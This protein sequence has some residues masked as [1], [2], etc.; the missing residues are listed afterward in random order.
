M[1]HSGE[2]RQR[3][4][5][6]VREALRRELDVVPPSPPEQ[7]W[8]GIRAAILSK[9]ERSFFSPGGVFSW[10]R[11]T[12]AAAVLLLLAGGGLALSRSPLL[13]PLGRSGC[14]SAQPEAGDNGAMEMCAEEK[15]GLPPLAP[16]SGFALEQAGESGLLTE[17]EH[18]PAALYRRGDETLLWACDSSSSKDLQD[19][20]AELG[21]QLGF[22]IKMASGER[23]YNQCE[24]L[25]LE[26]T[27]GEHPGIAWC[28]AEGFQAYLVLSGSVD[29]RALWESGVKSFCPAE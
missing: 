20:V 24:N 16:G 19:F 15:G 26:F 14:D 18:Y 25:Y 17:G 7:A 10:R 2:R 28:E 3:H 8:S 1:T 6:I 4:E 12:A 27:A 13:A 21:R 29:L 11:L 9:R 5:E 22:E 23:N